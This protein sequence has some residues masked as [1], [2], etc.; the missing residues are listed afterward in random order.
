MGFR[1]FTNL[2]VFVFLEYTVASNQL[3]GT[4]PSEFGALTSMQYLEMDRNLYTGEGTSVVE[5][6]WW[7][8]VLWPRSL[9]SV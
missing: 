2:P 6:G 7:T 9:I 3:S 4:L 5:I 8:K 1:F